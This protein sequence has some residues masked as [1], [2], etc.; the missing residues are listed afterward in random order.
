MTPWSGDAKT[1][2]GLRVLL[3]EYRVEVSESLENSCGN[4]AVFDM[5]NNALNGILGAVPLVGGVDAAGGEG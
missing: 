5:R 1:S 4:G 2:A 3:T